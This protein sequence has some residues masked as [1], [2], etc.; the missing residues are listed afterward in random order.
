MKWHT[1]TWLAFAILF[2]VGFSLENFSKPD[3]YGVQ[4]KFGPDYLYPNPKLTPGKVDTAKLSDLLAKYLCQKRMCTYSEAHRNVSSSEKNEV[5][6]KYGVNSTG[7]IDH[8][9]PLGLGGS[10]DISNLWPQPEHNIWNGTDYGFR[11]KDRLET[12]LIN[13]VKDSH[14]SP[15]DA[16]ECIRADWIMC[17]YKY[18][19]DDVFGANLD[20]QPNE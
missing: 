1:K 18:I 20:A 10:N 19:N 17:Y 6:A 11:K 3:T 8:F 4:K 2:L 12:Y 13:E 14:I 5:M 9:I 7:E 15:V 16:Q